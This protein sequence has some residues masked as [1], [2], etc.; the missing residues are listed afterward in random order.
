M[1]ERGT[2]DQGS[3]RNG[4][5][6]SP[7]SPGNRCQ[8]LIKCFHIEIHALCRVENR[9]LRGSYLM[10]PSEYE[11]L[12]DK[13]LVRLYQTTRDQTA[14]ETLVRRYEPRLV[15][16]CDR[17]LRNRALAEDISQAVFARLACGVDKY[18]GGN[19]AAWLFRIA[20]NECLNVLA[21]G[22]STET[23]T[24]EM[25]NSLAQEEKQEPHPLAEILLQ[26]LPK[27][28]SEQRICLKL[29]HM[30]GYSYDEVAAYTN[31]PIRNVK[32]HIQNGRKALRKRIESRRRNEEGTR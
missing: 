8:S 11:G 23:L 2:G 7:T 30:D 19:F 18:H 12:T 28:P 9:F 32:S 20:R 29:F 3:P 24:A 22:R 14:F 25:E 31:L 13:Q 27:L 15:R 16:F 10:R 21:R 5:S 26:E 4:G 6:A 1:V 17:F